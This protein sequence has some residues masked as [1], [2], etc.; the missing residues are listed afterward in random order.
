MAYSNSKKKEVGLKIHAG[1]AS[2]TFG[3]NVAKNFSDH[4]KR[5]VPLYE[6]GHDLVCKLSDFFVKDDSTCY[7]IGVSVGDLIA[8]LAKH[9]NKKN[10]KWIGI[11]TEKSMI[12]EAKNQTS[13]LK[14]VSLEIADVNLYDFE[15]SDFIVSYYTIQFIQPKLRQQLINKIFESLNW[16]GAFVWFEKIR[17]NDARFQDI[18]TTLYND[19]KLEQ[20]FNSDEIISKTRSLK[21]V[22]EPFSTQGNLDLLKRAGF[23]DI[24]I[25]MNYICFQG[26][27]AIK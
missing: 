11:D 14:N 13:G 19:Y 6:L 15:K 25:V 26:F 21:G 1:N 4:I 12:A 24:Q 27:L 8:K 7:E 18:M 3:G 16:S 23:V 5:S 2:W 9:N 10:A 17:G 20:K 22:L